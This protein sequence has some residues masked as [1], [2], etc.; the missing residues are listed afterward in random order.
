MNQAPPLTFR[1]LA[2]TIGLLLSLML[3]SVSIA[4]EPTKPLPTLDE[5]LGLDTPAPAS[6]KPVIIEDANDAQLDRVLS[7]RQAG[8]AFSQAVT[9][10]DQVASRIAENNDLSLA[11]Q[12]LQEDILAKLDKVIESANEN[13]SNSSNSSSSSQS[14]SSNQ[15]QPDQQKQPSDGQKNEQADGQSNESGESP[16]PA[17]TSTANPGDEIAPD[18]V[19]WGALPARI[20]DALSQGISDQ[21]SE[22]YRAITEEYYRSLAEDQNQ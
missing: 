7:P 1:L 20:R 3:I 2:R 8:E 19:S 9:L 13:N 16:M 18:G 22:L 21:Y 12:R 11:T 5:L 17:G 15:D 10:M 6:D 14:S 4:D